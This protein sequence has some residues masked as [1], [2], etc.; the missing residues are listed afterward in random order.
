MIPAVCF[1]PLTKRW[2]LIKGKIQFFIHVT[3][4]IL[5]TVYFIGK[6]NRVS[7]LITLRTFTFKIQGKQL[8]PNE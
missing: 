4:F 6:I 7:K 2:V 1:L 5:S 3:M 8:N